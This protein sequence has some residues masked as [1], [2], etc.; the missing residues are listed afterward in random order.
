MKKKICT[1]L[2]IG[3]FMV[4]GT[5]S[6]GIAVIPPDLKEEL[7]RNKKYAQENPSNA[8][9]WFKYAMSCAYTGQ[10]DDGLTALK[11]VDEIDGNYAARMAPVYKNKITEDQK[12]W[13]N[14]FYY[15]FSVYALTIEKKKNKLY[16]RNLLI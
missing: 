5:I 2:L 15:A 7:G 9:L 16:K 11:K 13:K 1:L 10:V 4:T 12:N 14:R 8:E 6:W 3:L